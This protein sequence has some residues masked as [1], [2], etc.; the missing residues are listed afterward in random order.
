MVDERELWDLGI[1][2]SRLSNASRELRDET[3]GVRTRWLKL[4]AT[5]WWGCRSESYQ[6]V[7]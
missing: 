6:M 4:D 7:G 1:S 3:I 5:G 2:I